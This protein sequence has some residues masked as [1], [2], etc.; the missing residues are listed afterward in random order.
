L[1]TTFSISLY[2][3]DD[4][5]IR[6]ELQIAFDQADRDQWRDFDVETF[7]AEARRRLADSARGT[8]AE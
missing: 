2:N 1:P 4:D 8:M 7:I 6:R 3:L 5:R